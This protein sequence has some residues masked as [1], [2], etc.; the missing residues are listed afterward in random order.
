MVAQLSETD[1]AWLAG[2]IDGEGYIGIVRIKKK[3]TR[4]SSDTWR[5][6]PWVIVT[7][8]D[9]K[10]LADIQLAVSTEKQASLS[11]TEGHKPAFQVKISKFD[12]VAQFLEAVLPY[13]RLKQK[14]AQLLIDFCKHRKSAKIITGRGHRGMTS[15][16][17][18]EEKIYL[19]LRELN[20]RGA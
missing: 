6:Y 4:Q 14:Q 11:R 17:E 3:V 2:F 10:V 8:T 9:T 19:K 5:Y 18:I 12:D 20:K 13:L 1:K 7:N 15:F 16:G